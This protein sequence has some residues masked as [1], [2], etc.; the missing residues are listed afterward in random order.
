MTERLEAY[1]SQPHLSQLHLA[2]TKTVLLAKHLLAITIAHFEGS[3]ESVKCSRAA[4]EELVQ[5]QTVPARSAD[6]PEPNP[7]LFA[8][9][10]AAPVA[11]ASPAEPSKPD[12]PGSGSVSRD[13]VLNGSPQLADEKPIPSLVAQADRHIPVPVHKAAAVFDTA[14]IQTPTASE[15]DQDQIYEDTTY[16]HKASEAEESS[17]HQT[18]VTT[19]A[20]ASPAWIDLPH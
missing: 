15:Q 9:P 5:P 17:A 19:C 20:A 2:S 3:P 1:T 13:S 11:S 8:A 16:A 6:S 7:I 10:K 14:L 18:T 4:P 12:W